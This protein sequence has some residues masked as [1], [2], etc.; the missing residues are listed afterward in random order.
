MA[1]MK[2]NRSKGRKTEPSVWGITAAVMAV[3][4]LAGFFLPHRAIVLL[5]GGL[6]VLSVVA[7]G[8]AFKWRETRIAAWGAAFGFV[9]I[10]LSFMGLG[11]TVSAYS[12]YKEPFLPFWKPSLILGLAV[13]IFV[14]VKWIWKGTGWVGRIGSIVVCTCMVF[15]FCWIPLCHLNYLLDPQPTEIH[16]VIEEKEKV[17]H[18]KS[19]DSYEFEMTVDGET[20]DLEVGRREYNRYEV[21]DTYTFKEYK[22]AFGKPFYI[23]EQ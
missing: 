1:K 15:L 4:C 18:R 5:S 8:A 23:A 19:P 12:F 6:G 3:V 14:T 20:F 21:G 17:R 13:G 22:G 16:A 10:L 2:A 11:F 7:V 9:G